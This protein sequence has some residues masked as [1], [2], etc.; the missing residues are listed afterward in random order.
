M[1]TPTTKNDEFPLPAKPKITSGRLVLGCLGIA[2]LAVVATIV[3]PW[4]LSNRQAAARLKAA[5]QR[6]RARGEPLNTVELNEFYVPAKGRPDMTREIL[7]ALAICEEAG[8]SP[9]AKTLPIVGQGAEPPPRDQP[10]AQLSEVEK[11][12][13]GQQQA[14][15]TFDQFPARD[16]TVRFPVD[17]T[18]GIATLLPNTQQIREGARALSLQFHVHRHKGEIAEAVNCIIAHLALSRALDGEP[19]MVSQLVRIAVVGMA[20]REIGQLMQ[21]AQVSDADLRRLQAQ[22]RKIDSKQGLK[23]ALVGERAISYTVCLD[24][25]QFSDV[26]E[27]RPGLGR[28]IMQRQPQ[29][30]FDAAKMLELNLRISEGADESLFKAWE[31]AQAAE[32]DIHKIAG[33]MIGKFYYMY[34]LLL[35]P[36]YTSGVGAFARNA[37]E[38]D[39]AD[40]A[41][42][43]ELYRRKNGKWPARLDD[44]VPEFLPAVPIDPF[45][46]RPLILKSDGRSCR[47]YSVG[48]DS[49]DQGGNFTG[50]QKP[51]SDVGFEV[52][53]PQ[54]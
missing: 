24:P 5:V 8:K 49:T 54:Q 2:L 51:G 45:T 44:L 53:A 9:A 22:L 14:F 35:S 17:F 32:D 48:N 37:A 18:P 12:L 10:W 15:A 31:E 1:A 21:E 33:N 16:G 30:V 3:I 27:I 46:N 6:V 36:A 47:I 13:A 29:R 7:E 50:D 28:E 39:S 25:K 19:I 23:N 26:Q 20:I 43:A 34:T 40:S 38:R 42:A 41:V 4:V 52:H 11:Y